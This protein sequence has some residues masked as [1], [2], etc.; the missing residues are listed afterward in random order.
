MYRP[1][2]SQCE[3][4][5]ER[6]EAKLLCLDSQCMSNKD[7]IEVFCKRMV[8]VVLRPLLAPGAC[9]HACTRTG[10][11]WGQGEEG[12]QNWLCQPSTQH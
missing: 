8:A 6:H 7:N 4:G 10:Q 1:E 11:D 12:E 3:H 2:E 9:V 5:G